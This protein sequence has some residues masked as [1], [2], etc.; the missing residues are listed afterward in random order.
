MPAPTAR[1][2]S[3]AFLR[4]AYDNYRRF[5]DTTPVDFDTIG[6]ALHSLR[7]MVLIFGGNDLSL[8][9]RE[10]AEL[11]A[12]ADRVKAYWLSQ[13]DCWDRHK[14]LEDLEQHTG[15]AVQLITE[16]YASAAEE[17]GP[18]F[19]IDASP[20]FPAPPPGVGIPEQ[21]IGKGCCPECAEHVM[22]QAVEK[23]RVA[24]TSGGSAKIDM[25][26]GCFATSSKLLTCSGCD[27]ARYCT[28]SCQRTHYSV[29]KEFCRQGK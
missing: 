27:K 9:L 15:R 1:E 3:A 13:P 8:D 17:W 16:L 24:L 22:G 21:A 7:S 4:R 5:L 11:N 23:R 2:E 12:F 29:H 14:N 25:C 10:L 20:G 6:E 26:D 28:A 19:A 18:I